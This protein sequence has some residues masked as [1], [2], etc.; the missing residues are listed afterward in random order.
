M[1]EF[2]LNPAEMLALM[3]AVNTSLIL[4]IDNDRLVPDQ[5]E[6]Q[7]ELALQGIE[8]L[9]QRALIKIQN[10]TYVLDGDL[11]LMA[12]AV[13]YPQVLTFITRD[14]PGQGQQQFLHYRADPVN[15]E[16]TMPTEEE[17]RLAALPDAVAALARI[18]Q[19]LPVTLDYKGAKV[20]QSLEQ[21]LFFAVKSLAEA[22]QQD[23]AGATLQEAGFP[24]EAAAQFVQ[25][26]HSP[27]LGGTVAFMRVQDQKIVDGRNL[28]MVHDEQIAWL[29]Y[30]ATA[31]EASLI[32]ETVTPVE[33]STA[34]LDTLNNLLG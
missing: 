14:L 11:G 23:Q 17:Y 10:G 12:A 3:T 31:G 28:A 33:Y 18:R 15:V 4:G 19:I 9:K 16:L 26:L 5:Q 21:E 24:A 1:K 6:Q 20:R 2:Q 13:A 29:I 30:Q 22:G 7:Q 8:Q 27:T 25:T 34:L 32:I